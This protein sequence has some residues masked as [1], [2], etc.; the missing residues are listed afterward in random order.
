[1]N[2]EDNLHQPKEW[3]IFLPKY[4]SASKDFQK[5]HAVK[6]WFVTYLP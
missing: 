4:A 2:E 1:M 5:W 6:T 3:N